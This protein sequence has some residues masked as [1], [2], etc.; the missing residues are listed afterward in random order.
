M[1]IGRVALPARERLAQL[2]QG[3]TTFA[4][5]RT[6]KGAQPNFAAACSLYACGKIGLLRYLEA[7]EFRGVLAHELAFVAF[8]HFAEFASQDFL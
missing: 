2:G 7:V 1:S 4:V 5:R 6:R 3:L 8:R